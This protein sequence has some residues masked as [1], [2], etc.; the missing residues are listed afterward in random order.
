MIL[1]QYLIDMWKNGEFEVNK[2]LETEI[3]GNN[4]CFLYPHKIH[5]GKVLTDFQF[6]RHDF[7]KFIG[8]VKMA[9]PTVYRSFVLSTKNSA[10]FKMTGYKYR[11]STDV[12]QQPIYC[13]G[14]EV[15]SNCGHSVLYRCYSDCDK[16]MLCDLETI[17][18]NNIL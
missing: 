1:T 8:Y 3:P 12:T 2:F 5:T 16:C 18:E 17:E 13:D 14:K 10:I 11:D 7:L 15:I 9:N 6:N 4:L